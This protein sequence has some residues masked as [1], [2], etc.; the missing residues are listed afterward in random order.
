MDGEKTTI[1]LKLNPDLTPL[2]GILEIQYTIPADALD[3]NSGWRTA[4]D[5]PTFR[6][7]AMIGHLRWQLSLPTPMIAVTFGRQVRVDSQWALQGWLLTPEPSVTAIA[8][9]H[10][11]T[12]KEPTQTPAHVTFAFAQPSLQP[13]TV[14]HWPRQWWLLGC[15]GIFLILALGVYFAPVPRFVFALLLLALAVGC[16]TLG[17]VWPATLAPVLFG[18]QPG[19]VLLTIFVGIHWAWQERSR[20]QLVFLPAFSRTKP[21]STVTTPA[22]A[23]RPREPSTVDAPAPLE[24]G[25]APSSSGSQARS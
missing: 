7:E 8:L 21:G 15:S 18:C 25:P 3:R 10:W 1:R 17:I 20:R 5:A 2:P 23:K 13:L 6:S 22:G 4:L 14:Y 11:L 12:D 16:L 19:V 24:G 9:E